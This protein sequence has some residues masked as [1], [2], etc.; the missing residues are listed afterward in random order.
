[1]ENPQLRESFG[2]NLKQ[3]GVLVSRVLP[4]SAVAKVLEAKDV[5][6][7]FEGEPI[8]NDGTIRFRKHERVM[9]TWL[10]A[11]KFYGE[12]ASLTVLRDS[13]QLELQIENFHPEVPLVPIHMF[14]KPNPG[15]SY[16][17]VAGLVL[18][19]LSEPFLESEYGAEWDHKAPVEF[20]KWATQDHAESSDQQLVIL[21][22]VLAHEITM[23]YESLE[24]QRLRTVNGEAVRNLRHAM[25]LI[26]ACKS[27][28]LR[29][30]L[31]H[32]LV[33]ILKSEEAKAT[34][35]AV[36]KTYGIPAAMSPDLWGPAK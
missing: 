34:T 21:T 25:E 7:A 22:Q 15:P 27:G 4:T 31:E 9:Y 6:L 2:M 16:Y 12:K 36:L 18:T 1:M 13:K 32:N 10:V 33:L 5:L 30:G 19:T 14:N 11:Q 24:H 28:Y 17:I 26:E 29:F 23:G 8:G 3:K 35:P 20:V